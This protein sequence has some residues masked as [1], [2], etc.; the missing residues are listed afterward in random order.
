MV[1]GVAGV[2]VLIAGL[3]EGVGGGAV[4]MGLGVVDEPWVHAR[5]ER[6]V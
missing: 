2:A 5:P 4:G 3:L 1:L 6:P